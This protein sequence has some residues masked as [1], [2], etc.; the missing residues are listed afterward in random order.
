MKKDGAHTHGRVT[1]DPSTR[2]RATPGLDKNT[3][4]HTHDQ[5]T[6]DRVLEAELPLT[7]T[8]LTEG[9]S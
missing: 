9:Y 8:L 6:F 4:A 5:V 2:D 7:E 3:G 1:F